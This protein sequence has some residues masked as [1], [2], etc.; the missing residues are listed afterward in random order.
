MRPVSRIPAATLLPKARKPKVTVA[1]PAPKKT[2]SAVPTS[3]AA[4]WRAIVASIIADPPAGPDPPNRGR[5]RPESGSDCPVAD[6]AAGLLVDLGVIS[7]P[8]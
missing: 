6:S 1:M 8:H 3:S 5:V 2:S 4:Y 7:H